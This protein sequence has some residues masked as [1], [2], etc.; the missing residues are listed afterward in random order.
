MSPGNHALNHLAFGF[1]RVEFVAAA[2]EEGL[3]SRGEFESLAKF[4]SV[5][6]GDD[7]LGAIDIREHVGRHKLA[8]TIVTVGIVRLENA[9]AILDRESRRNNEESAGESIAAG[10]PRGIDRLPRDDHRHDGRLAGSGGELE[11]EPD[12][13]RVRFF[14]RIRKMVQESLPFTEVGGLRSARLLSP[15]LRF[16]RRTAEHR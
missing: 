14:V 6:I 16:G 5:V 3:G 8:L 13:F 1:L 15:P 9:K 2:S 7:D 11:R 4:E 10:L 12:Q